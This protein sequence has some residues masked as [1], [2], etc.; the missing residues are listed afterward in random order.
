MRSCFLCSPAV[1]IVNQSL[2]E[3]MLREHPKARLSATLMLSLGTAYL[4]RRPEQ[5]L[6]LYVAVLLAA[7]MLSRP[8]PAS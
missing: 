1:R 4:A 2:L 6:W 8:E 3:H 5:L 7:W